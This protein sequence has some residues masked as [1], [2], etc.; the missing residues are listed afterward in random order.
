EWAWDTACELQAEMFH[1][2]AATGGLDMQLVYYRGLGECR[3]SRWILDPKQL[4]KTMSQIMCNEFGPARM[5]P[6]KDYVLIKRGDVLSGVVEGVV[7]IERVR[8]GP[9]SA[10]HG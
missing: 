3:S 2:V 6:G 8:G 4:A 7:L 10:S 9:R 5:P 1:E